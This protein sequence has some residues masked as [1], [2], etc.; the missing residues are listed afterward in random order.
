MPNAVK[1]IPDGFTAVTP[2]LRIKG[3][4][5]AMEFYKQ[6][7]GA[8]ELFRMPMPD[9]RVGHAEMVIGGAIV[10]LAD[11]FP[12][13]GVF[14]PGPQGPGVG[15]HLYVEDVDAAYQRAVSAGAKATMPPMDMFWG[16]RYGKL[17]DPYGHEWSLATHKEDVSPEEMARRGKEAM[18][19]MG[20]CGKK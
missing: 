6:A 19:N 4:G 15:I 11:E 17:T 2:H 7:F 8:E 1:A 5:A 20:D 12:E 9:G 16:D 10:M 3:A 13:M 18:A 14:G